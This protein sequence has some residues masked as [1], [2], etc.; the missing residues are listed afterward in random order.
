MR[1]TYLAEVKL[2]TASQVHEQSGLGSRNKSE[3]ASRWKRD[4]KIFAV[5][6]GVTYLYQA[7]QYENG[8]TRRIIGKIL[9]DI[10]D[11]F[12]PWQIAF[13]FESGNGWLNGEEPQNCL[14]RV[15]DMI[16]AAKRFAEPTVG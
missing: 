3:Q 16:M 13:W 9:A 2:L 5:R 10:N 14:D 15:E 6:K 1:S 12:T 8:Q 11:K 4:S 7:F